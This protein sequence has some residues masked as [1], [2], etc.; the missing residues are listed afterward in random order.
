[1][2]KR[3]I[4]DT[5][6]S[7]LG[8]FPAVAILGCRQVGKT[9]LALQLEKSI[10]KPTDYFDLELPEDRAKLAEPQIFLE[11]HE[12]HLLILDEI[13]RV[14]ELFSVMRGLIDRRRRKGDKAGHYLIL[15]SA[16]P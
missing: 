1:M 12:N 6:V 3:R 5:V 13:H 14:P 16:S 9:T 8:K 15:G 10:G 7:S 2:I 4:F 11:E